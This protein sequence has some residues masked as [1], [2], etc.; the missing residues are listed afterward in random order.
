MCVC[1][2]VCVFNCVSACLCVCVTAG[3]T[4][5]NTCLHCDPLWLH[6]LK[7]HGL[8]KPEDADAVAGV[9]APD[10]SSRK[11]NKAIDKPND[12][13]SYTHTLIDLCTKPLTASLTNF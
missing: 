9:A 3:C 5:E 4:S 6:P 8:W 12:A 13:S 2:L 11:I 10:A 7:A 1:V